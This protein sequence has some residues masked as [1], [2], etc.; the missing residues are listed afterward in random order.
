MVRC[1]NCLANKVCDHNR[2]GFENCGSYISAA[3]VAP[4]SEVEELKEELAT[5]RRVCG[6][7]IIRDGIV[8]GKSVGKE[9]EYI[10]RDISK[11][12]RQMAIREAKRDV[13]REI[14]EDIERK[15][16]VISETNHSTG[17][18][19]VVCYQISAES[20]AELKKKYP[21]EKK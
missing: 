14:F 15:S 11:I 17:Y 6:E 10:H 12:L 21:E 13:A 18:T 9:V 8:V 7:L 4:K 2:F 20:I 16:C 1:D 5:Y 3:D 19:R